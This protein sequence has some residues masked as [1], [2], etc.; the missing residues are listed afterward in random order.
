MEALYWMMKGGS[1]PGGR[2]RNTTWLTAVTWATALAMLTLRLKEDLDDAGAVVGLRLDVLDVVDRRGHDAFAVGDEAG[3]H[4]L[5]G[6]A[7]VT[8]D[9]GDD[10]DIDIGKDVHRHRFD[11]EDAHDQMRSAKTTNV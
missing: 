10:G 11:A 2:C 3:G 5:R 7:G 1:A 4:L 9:H 6:E 8:P